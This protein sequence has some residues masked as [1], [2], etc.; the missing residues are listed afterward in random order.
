ME[1]TRVCQVVRDSRDNCITV[2]NMENFDPLA[3]GIHTGDSIVVA[4][5]QSLTNQKVLYVAPHCDQG[6]AT[7]SYRWG[8]QYPIR[9]PPRERALLHHRSQ[10]ASV[11]IVSS[12]FQSYRLSSCICRDQDISGKGS[13]VDSKLVHEDNHCVLP[14]KG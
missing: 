6:C 5:S 1:R 10:C 11:P 7:P 8:M 9:S 4:P 13:C 2:C 3:L 12:C 14:L